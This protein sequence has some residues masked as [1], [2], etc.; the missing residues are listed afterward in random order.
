MLEPEKASPRQ[1][2]IRVTLTLLL[3]YLI[4]GV[5][6][7]SFASYEDVWDALTSLDPLTVLFLTALTL[8]VE[9][10][11]AGAFA[12]IIE[13]LRFPDAFLAQESAAVIS[14]TVPGPSG[15]AARYVTY[16]KLGISTEDFATSYVVNSSVSNVLPLV[17]P[18]I[19]LALLSTQ[20]DVPGAVWTLALVGLGVSLALL[21]LAVLIM[22]SEQFARR[23][24]ARVGRFLN[25]L[26]GMARRPPGEELGETV[27]KWRSDVVE[28]LPA[29]ALGLVG[30]F[31]L[32]EVATYVILLASL[33][34]MGVDDR[35]L[36][37]DRGLRGL[38][39]GPPR[40]ARRDHTGQCRHR[41][42]ALHQRPQLGRGWTRLR[43]HRRGRVRLPDVHLPRADPH[44]GRVHGPPVAAVPQGRSGT[45]PLTG[46]SDPVIEAARTR[47]TQRNRLHR[48][49]FSWC[50]SGVAAS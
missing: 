50:C 3:L 11:K 6:I 10:C 35:V 14:N 16:R 28:H 13:P 43:R 23:F 19:G 37:A 21:V 45:R 48:P 42:G 40:D 30:L 2:I 17:L 33:R 49:R 12:L 8:V 15:T 20:S 38:H 24:G 4:F 39:G 9:G 1:T 27:V 29:R 47:P 31:V 22:R 26:R 44:R 18:S 34:A 5:L 7:P 32:R 46:R 25:W 41:R 36:T